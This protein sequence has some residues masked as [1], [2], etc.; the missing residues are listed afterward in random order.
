M[1]LATDSAKYAT[2]G[3]EEKFWSIWHEKFENKEVEQEYKIKLQQL[4]NEPLSLEQKNKL[5]AERFRYVRSYFDALESETILPTQQDEYLYNLCR[6]ER[7]MDL[8][9]NFTLF[10]NGEK[11]IA[12]YQQYFAIKKTMKRITSFNQTINSS[13]EGRRGGQEGWFGTRREVANR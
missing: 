4:K 11:K 8:I 5:F 7:L 2:N 6:R 13:N 12:R 1:S 9:F 3:T 10:D